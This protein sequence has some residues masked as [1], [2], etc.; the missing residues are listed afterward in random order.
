MLTSCPHCGLPAL[1]A[2]RKLA[3]GP[4]A[5]AACR[6]CGL[7]VGV[8]PWPA[9]VSLAPCAAVVLAVAAGWLTR[10]AT[11]IACGLAAIAVTCVAYLTAV[12]LVPRQRTDMKAV[13]AA[14]SQ[15]PDP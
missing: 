10:P 7:A 1:P 14:R 2:W 15:A 13:R 5:K 9:L 11:T 6:R 3:L 8:A 4:A 12:P